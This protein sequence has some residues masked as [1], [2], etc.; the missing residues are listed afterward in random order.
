MALNAEWLK[1]HWYYI[2]AGFVGII[3]LYEF[4]SSAS[5]A[6][7]SSSST[8]GADNESS[9][10]AQVDVANAQANSQTEIANYAAQVAN[11]QTGAELQLGLAQTT[12]T[13]AI[14]EA[15]IKGADTAQQIQVNGEDTQTSDIA[16][17]LETLGSQQES[18][19]KDIIGTVNSQISNIMTYSPNAN[20][21]F[22]AFAP[23][24]EAELGE[25][26]AASTTSQAN[27]G[28]NVANSTANKQLANSIFSGLNQ[29]GQQVL[30]GLFGGGSL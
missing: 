24:L 26:S 13:Q 12:A 7:S 20:A 1:S 22:E 19:Q 17:L 10:E 11:T 29:T 23:L 28:A 15:E 2:A 3:I 21:S 8:A 30:A 9:L 4:L 6:S 27:E 18:V 25:G 14:D 5:G 16:N